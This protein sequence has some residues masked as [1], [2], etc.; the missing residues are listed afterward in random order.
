MYLDK[1]TFPRCREEL[2]LFSPEDFH[3]GPTETS[4]KTYVRICCGG[5][6]GARLKGFAE[7]FGTEDA[8]LVGDGF[9]ASNSLIGYME[10]QM[11]I[12]FFEDAAD[13]RKWLD[14]SVELDFL[15]YNDNSQKTFAVSCPDRL[16]LGKL[17]ELVGGDVTTDLDWRNVKGAKVKP[18]SYIDSMVMVPSGAAPYQN[19]PLSV[20]KD[21]RGMYFSGYVTNTEGCDVEGAVFYGCQ[22]YVDGALNI[23]VDEKSFNVSTIRRPLL[24]GQS[25]IT[26]GLY[27]YVMGSNPSHFKGSSELPVETVSWFDLLHFCNKLSEMQG[28]TPCYYNIVGPDEDGSAE[29]DRSANGYRLLTEKE[30][31][32]IARANRTF[33]YSGSDDPNEVAWYEENSDGKTHP[34]GTKKGNAFGTYDQSGNLFEWCW[35]LYRPEDPPRVVRGGLWDYDASDIRTAYG[36]DFYPS[37]QDFNVGGRLARSPDPLNP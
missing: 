16:D 13:Y 1:S 7:L 11:I 29:W 33:E 34:V 18:N 30:W 36:D 5:N 6:T 4:R 20:P 22:K 10:A 9:A 8:Y 25:L 31:E 27:G 23:A 28:F 12:L 15:Q 35:D 17:S 37:Y 26:Q 19:E 21:A 24:V 14:D 3:I 32:Y 2:S